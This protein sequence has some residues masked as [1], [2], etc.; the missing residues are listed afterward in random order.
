MGTLAENDEGFISMLSADGTHCPIEE[1]RPLSSEWSSH[2]L[3]GKAGPNCKLCLLTHKPKLVWCNGPAR[4]GK[5]NDLQVFQQKLKPAL[6]ALPGS[7]KVVGNSICGAEPDCATTKND[8]DPPELRNF[9]NR[10]ETRQENFNGFIKNWGCSKKKFVHGVDLHM[11]CFRAV[12]CIAQVQLFRAVCCI[13]QVQLETGGH[14]LPDPCP[15]HNKVE[16]AVIIVCLAGGK[17]NDCICR[18]A[19]AACMLSTDS[20]S[21]CA[22]A[23]VLVCILFICVESC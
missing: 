16:T 15:W 6:D 3:G 11:T 4:P 2:K 8:L 10:V 19:A 5:H 17:A 22:T 21:P 12:C 13:A 9:K 23:L 7:R 20:L 14:S 1:P 18:P